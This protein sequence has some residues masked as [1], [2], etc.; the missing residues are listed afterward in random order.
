L[1]NVTGQLCYVTGLKVICHVCKVA[2]LI[3]ATQLKLH[4]HV[5]YNV[6]PPQSV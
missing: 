3:A 5:I 2:A 1:E 6:A 4:F